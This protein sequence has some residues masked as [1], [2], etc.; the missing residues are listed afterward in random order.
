MRIIDHHVGGN[1]NNDDDCNDQD[2]NGIF[3]LFAQLPGENGQASRFLFS[4]VEYYHISL[5]SSFN[6]HI[7]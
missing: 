4:A 5:L 7:S 1:D 2:K 6:C 3:L